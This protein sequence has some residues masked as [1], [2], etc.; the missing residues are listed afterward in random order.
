[1]H[2]TGLKRGSLT[3]VGNALREFAAPCQRGIT[4][5]INET[6][7]W[8][9]SVREYGRLKA[10]NQELKKEIDT[11]KTAIVR[12][13]EVKQ[14]NLRLRNLLN[15]TTLYDE[16]LDFKIAPVIGR[17][18][19]NWYHTLTLGIGSEEGL[20]KNQVVITSKGVVGRIIAVT[21]HTAEVLLIFDREGAIGGIVQVNRTPGVVEGSSEYRGYL[22][23]IHVSRDAP[24]EENQVVVTSGLGGIYP[25]GLVIGTIVKVI[26]EPNG[27][28]KRAIIKPAADFERLEEVLVITRVKGDI[29]N[30][31]PGFNRTRVD[32]VNP[33]NNPIINP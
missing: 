2:W 23:M 11:L 18:P 6:G 9:A 19:N 3:I 32:R 13:E 8:L 20:K 31:V 24:L 30:A 16:A 1:M 14:E 29:E 17:S 21:P 12:M 22:Q 33:G 25:K 26:P 28:M 7:D 27:L 4:L 15:Y 10:R 5:V